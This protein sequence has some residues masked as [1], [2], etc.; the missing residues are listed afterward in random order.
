MHDP[1]FSAKLYETR[2][3]KLQY[4]VRSQRSHLGLVTVLKCKDEGR[5]S[6]EGLILTLEK[7]GPGIP[8]EII[9]EY[10]D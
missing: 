6:F 4:I 5:K 10:V 8:S 7:Q 3:Y 9:Y 1:P 2:V